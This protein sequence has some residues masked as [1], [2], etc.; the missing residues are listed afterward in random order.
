MRISVVS[1]TFAIVLFGLAGCSK[2]KATCSS[3]EGIELVGQIISEAAEKSLTDQ[4]HAD[5]SAAF[6]AASVRATLSKIAIT[7]ENIRTSKE[8]PNSTKVFCEGSIKITVPPELLKKAEEGRELANLGTVTVLASANS[9]EQS[10]NTFTKSIEYNVQPTDDGK[11]MFAELTATKPMAEF[12]SEVTGSV[13]IK[14]IIEANK[15]QQAKAEETERLQ[16]EEQEKKQQ[17]EQIEAA[18]IQAKQENT[19]ANQ[20]IGEL[21]KNIPEDERKLMLDAQRA[22]IKKKD[23]DCKVESAAKSTVPSEKEIYRLNC[24]TAATTARV[25][26]IQQGL[27]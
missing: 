17:V 22:W 26:E 18:L 10:A 20:A 4:K 15:I 21:W 5:G 23:L 24:D 16:A 14:P 13:I 1:A 9:L 19:L 6:D 12:L 25:S 3:Q 7:V 8:D 11:K 2:P 27:K